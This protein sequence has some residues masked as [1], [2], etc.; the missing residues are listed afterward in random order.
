MRKHVLSQFP[1]IALA[2]STW[3]VSNK[4][5]PSKF[6]D[7][8]NSDI[9]ECI[10]GDYGNNSP[11]HNFLMPIT[12]RRFRSLKVW[13]VIRTFGVAGLQ[14]YIRNVSY[15]ICK[16]TNQ[17]ITWLMQSKCS[18]TMRLYDLRQDVNLRTKNVDSFASLVLF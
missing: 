9:F 13:F 1:L 17:Y 5:I 4:T 10:H 8:F 2:N 15:H 6:N 14:E 3:K 7:K 11:T 16:C 12:I 18:T